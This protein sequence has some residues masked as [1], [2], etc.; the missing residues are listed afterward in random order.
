MTAR[1]WLWLWGPV[2]AFIAALYFASSRSDL[3]ALPG[4]VS[5]KVAHFAAYTVLSALAFRGFAGGGW[6]GVHVRSALSAFGLAAG[7]GLLDEVHQRFVPGRFAAVDDWIADALGAT[8]AV[9]LGVIAARVARRLT[10]RRD[11]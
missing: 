5:D 9:L 11:V 1:R 7:Y 10:A 4:G 3:P 8:A 2:V 6:A